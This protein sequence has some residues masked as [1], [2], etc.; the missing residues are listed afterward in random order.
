MTSKLFQAAQQTPVTSKV[1]TQLATQRNTARKTYT[2]NLQP[3]AQ[4]A[5]GAATYDQSGSKVLDLFS[6][7]ASMRSATDEAVIAM[8]SEAMKEEPALAAACLFYIRDVLKGQGERRFFRVALPYIAKNY[9]K[10]MEKLIPLIPQYGR[11][12]DLFCLKDTGFYDTALVFYKNQLIRD[13][14]TTS[15]SISL[16]AKWAPSE[17]GGTRSRALWKDFVKYFKSPRAYRKLVSTLRKK[18]EIVETLMSQGRW[19]EIQFDE[20]PSRASLIYR[21]AFKKHD[22]DRY[23]AFI[24][25][26][27]ATPKEERKTNIKSATLYPYEITSQAYDNA[28]DRTL[29]ALWEALPD[30]LEGRH[31][32][33]LAIVDTSGSMT[34]PVGPKSK[35]EIKDVALSLGVYLAERAKGPWAGQFITFSDNPAFQVIR[36]KTLHEKLVKMSRAQW[37]MTTNFTRV[38]DQILAVAKKNN[39]SQEDLP[40]TLFV[41]SDMEFNDADGKGAYSRR[42]STNFEEIERKFREAG[43]I[44]PNIVFWNVSGTSDNSPVTYNQ[45]GVAMVSGFSANTFKL[46]MGGGSTSEE[47]MRQFLEEERYDAVRAAFV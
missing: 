21:K 23:S 34:D 7:G 28:N 18:L 8:V 17:K 46:V 16:A 24:A 6:R 27:L 45:Y 10:A 11:W 33:A 47:I 20:V 13:I 5:N 19:D 4:T 38:F 42:K 39:L 29:D 35:V 43:Y 25:E 37:D 26:I 36:G 41:I 31:N 9:P 14:E 2:N 1:T 12:D 32:N 22:G 44:R 30:Y 15:D 3:T 40:E